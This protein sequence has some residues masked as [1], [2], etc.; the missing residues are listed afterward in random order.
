M[1]HGFRFYVRLPGSPLRPAGD[2]D[3]HWFHNFEQRTEFYPVVM[4]LD[5]YLVSTSEAML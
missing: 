1:I 3:S 5:V 4:I 2:F